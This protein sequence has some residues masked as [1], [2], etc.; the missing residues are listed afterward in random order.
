M[1]STELT[2]RNAD[3]QADREALQNLRQAVFTDE[4]NV[5]P[6]IEWD[7]QDEGSTHFLVEQ[8][9]RAIACARLLGDGKIGRMA[10]L[11]DHRRSGI[12][13]K[14]LHHILQQAGA[15]GRRRVFLHAQDHALS[16]YLDAGFTIMGSEFEEAGISHRAM[17]KYLPGEARYPQPFADIA[18]HLV[19]R[20]RR[21]L[22]LY[23]PRLDHQ[24][25]DRSELA[26]AL[27]DF[28]RSS[29]HSE[30]RIL[31][32]DSRPLVSRGHRLV[33]L[34]RRLPS[35]IAIQTLTHHPELPTDTFLLQ[36]NRGTLFKP[37][38]ADRKGFV[39]PD[40]GAV[41][42]KY[43]ETFDDLWLRSRPDPELRILGL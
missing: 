1:A 21:Q 31:I 33:S 25:F 26:A 3:W 40:N 5:P 35:K 30:V 4:Q 14:L 36:D 32:C 9:D 23:S 41:C 29:R 24:A 42:L 12:G 10:V 20:A 28:A 43:Q 11:A 2:I 18:V 16:F 27:T 34:M 13:S 39:E 37:N 19:R 15:A 7:G 38:D 17:E 22:R 8:D 6:D